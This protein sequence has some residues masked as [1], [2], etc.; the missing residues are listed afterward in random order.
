M[1]QD[2][3]DVFCSQLY[4]TNETR[5][6]VSSI[7]LSYD[8]EVCKSNIV[9]PAFHIFFKHSVFP[10]QNKPNDKPPAKWVHG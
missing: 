10:K 7:G 9:S 8:I 5:Q 1:K 4:R 3:I 2:T 6:E